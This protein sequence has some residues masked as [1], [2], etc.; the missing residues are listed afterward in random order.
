MHRQTKILTASPIKKSITVLS[1]P[2]KESCK[3]SPRKC[4][5]PCIEGYTYCLSHI[6][7][8]KNAPYKPCS[9]VYSVTGKKCN[10]P[11]LKSDRKEVLGLCEDHFQK[12]HA[13]KQKSL[14]KHFPPQTTESLL[15]TLSHYTGCKK[16]EENKTSNREES[17]LA[18][19]SDINQP[20]KAINPF[21]EADAYK[22]N[23]KGSLVLDYASESDSDVEPSMLD[24]VWRAQDQESSDAESIDSQTEDPLKHAGIYT[25]EEVTAISKQK[26][27]RLQSLYIDQYR[28]LQ[29][30]LK[31]RRRKY[32]QALK[33]EKETLCSIHSQSRN[34]FKEQKIYQKLLA[35][36]R[37]QRPNGIEGILYKKSQERRAEVTE[38]G[39]R[40][41]HKGKCKFTEGGVKC[42]AK[43]LPATKFCRKH[44]LEDTQ[45]LLYR[46]CGV[47]KA[48]LVCQ[49]PTLTVFENTTCIYHV[50]IPSQFHITADKSV[51]TDDTSEDHV[52]PEKKKSEENTSSE[53]I[54]VDD[55]MDVKK[56]NSITEENT[57]DLVME[58]IMADVDVVEEVLENDGTIPKDEMPDTK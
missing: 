49:E 12:S 14:E 15:A 36:N 5:Q 29:H 34:T 51:R 32:L 19:S 22:V 41:T 31:E 25:A 46:S 39:T 38:G 52:T 20:T 33:K 27:I 11:A 37:Y 44:I 54:D 18:E 47:Q 57:E 43:T 21:V 1:K 6:L 2:I 8:D 35:L 45:Q 3:Y 13:Q 42:G 58:D 16:N 24:S 55:S 26:L 40:P 4:S 10:Q 53:L 17:D 48:D 7:E 9:Y 23:A 30:H 56:T 50:P 28:R